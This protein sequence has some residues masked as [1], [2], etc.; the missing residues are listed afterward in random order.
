MGYWLRP[1]QPF[2]ARLLIDAMGHFSP[3]ARQAR[4]GQQPDGVCL[5]VGTCAQGY[6]HNDS[7]DLIVSFTPIR[8]Q[9]QYFWEAFPA[10]D[11][12]TTY[13]FTYLDAQPERI[14]LTDFFEDYWRLLPEYQQVSLEQLQVK[15]ALF[16]S[17]PAIARVHCSTPGVALWPWG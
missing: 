4:D 16:G 8:N 15:R 1:E 13:M 17:F 3:I 5:V 7:G 10:R 12:R 14:S 9:C 2:H 6:E 11:G